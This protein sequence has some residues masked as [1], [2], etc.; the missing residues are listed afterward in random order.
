MP[1]LCRRRNAFS[2]TD[3][4]SLQH[5][6]SDVLPRYGD[7]R[8]RLT[9]DITLN[10]PLLSAAMDTVTES[11]LAIALAQE[12]GIGIIHKSM[13]IGEQA[14]HVRNVKKYEAGIITD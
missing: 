4:A 6:Y 3:P 8:T 7:L 13:P 5:A 9:R 14:R 2:C 12:G 10:L 11:R 1:R